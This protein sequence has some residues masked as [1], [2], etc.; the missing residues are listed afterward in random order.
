[1]CASCEVVITA[2]EE[3]G[4][5]GYSILLCHAMKVTADSHE[6]FKLVFGVILVCL[7]CLGGRYCQICAKDCCMT[8]D[9]D[10]KK[11]PK[12][13][14]HHHHHHHHRHDDDDDDDKKGKWCGCSG[15]SL[16]ADAAI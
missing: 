13:Q 5:V 8:F 7:M 2:H 14:H 12:Q 11:H 6:V 9:C 15:S 1:M 3:V 4:L 10:D 16:A